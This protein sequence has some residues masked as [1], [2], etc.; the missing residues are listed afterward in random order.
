MRAAAQCCVIEIW[1]FLVCG[2]FVTC[3]R[4]VTIDLA[5][6]CKGK[7]VLVTCFVPQKKT[8]KIFFD[9]RSTLRFEFSLANASEN[10]QNAPMQL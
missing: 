10:D 8:I 3:F 7:L 4:R 9:A 1:H 2:A 6:I 5:G